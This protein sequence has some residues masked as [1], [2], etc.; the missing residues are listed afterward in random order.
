MNEAYSPLYGYSPL[1]QR[2]IDQY[3]KMYLPIVDLRMVTPDHRCGRQ[4]NCRR[5][6]NAFTFGSVTEIAWTPFAPRM[7]L[8]AK[9]IVH[10]TTRQNA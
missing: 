9:G 7:V 3:V 4:V 2:Q 6:F 8:S 10:E 1:S 5:H